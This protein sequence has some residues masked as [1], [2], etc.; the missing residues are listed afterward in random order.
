MQAHKH[1]FEFNKYTRVQSIDVNQQ[2]KL[3]K[4]SIFQKKFLGPNRPVDKHHFYKAL[5]LIVE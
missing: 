1:F 3:Q 4:L 5:Y 2:K